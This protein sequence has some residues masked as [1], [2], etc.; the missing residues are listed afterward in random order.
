[1]N[2]IPESK[3]EATAPRTEWGPTEAELLRGYCATGC[4]TP[5]AYVV[6]GEAMCWDCAEEMGALS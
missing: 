3:P 5:P 1:M 6:A 4:S 2:A